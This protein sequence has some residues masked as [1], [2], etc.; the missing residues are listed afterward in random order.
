MMY[1]KAILKVMVL[2]A[3]VL[4]ST[5]YVRPVVAA[6]QGKVWELR[7]AVLSPDTSRIVKDVMKPWAEEVRRATGGKV[8]IVIYTSQ[9]LCK[10]GDTMDAVKNGIA[11]LGWAWPGLKAGVAPLSEVA[12]LPMIYQTAVIG[13]KS[14]WE[15]YE[16]FPE[17]QRDYMGYKVITL[18]ACAPYPIVSNKR[19]VRSMKD[20]KGMKIRAG[21]PVTVGYLKKLGATPVMIR[22][23]D[24]YLAMQKGTI[25]A[26]TSGSSTI[27]SFKLYEV[28]RYYTYPGTIP[29]GHF[30]I[31][32]EGVW[33][34]MP[35]EIQKQIMSVSGKS[36][37]V[38]F[39]RHFDNG[40]KELPQNL[41]KAGAKYEFI[42]L[43]SEEQILW[44]RN[45][46]EVWEKWASDL[47]KKGLPG[48]KVLNRMNE[49]VAK[50]GCK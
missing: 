6:D 23:N 33:K 19:P 8:K 47:E 3:V 10:V 32:N 30:I 46:E 7:F 37:S 17:L 38:K 48:R 35:V 16:T 29:G 28:S 45:A 18:F 31:M 5:G 24:L 50:N 12:M 20:L 2:I 9:S 21:A 26:Y 44:K 39:G 34:S 36:L 25:D 14:L 41:S 22:P 27:I 43:T 1:K 49:L 13:S 15:L 11:D 40:V 4:A 42:T